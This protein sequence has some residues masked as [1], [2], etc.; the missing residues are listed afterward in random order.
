MTKA[1]LESELTELRSA[2]ASLRDQVASWDSFRTA[3]GGHPRAVISRGVVK[4]D[5]VCE[6]LKEASRRIVLSENFGDT[7]AMTSNDNARQLIILGILLEAVS[8]CKEES[9]NAILIRL[10]VE[11]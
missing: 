5:E 7:N 3:F 4:A 10:S 11:P 2:N 8:E 6:T 1:E 9:L